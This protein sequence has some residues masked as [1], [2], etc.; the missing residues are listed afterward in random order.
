MKVA[1]NKERLKAEIAKAVVLKDAGEA[2]DDSSEPDD[3]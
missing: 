1:L 2:D 3:D